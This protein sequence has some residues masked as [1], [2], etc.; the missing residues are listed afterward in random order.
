M[1]IITLS[2]DRLRF[3]DTYLHICQCP[4]NLSSYW[5]QGY[6]NPGIRETGWIYVGMLTINLLVCQV[7]KNK[8]NEN[9][10]LKQNKISKMLK[11]TS[12]YSMIENLCTW[13]MIFLR[14][15]LMKPLFVVKM[16]RKHLTMT[17]TQKIYF[18]FSVLI[19]VTIHW[20][21]QCMIW[22]KKYRYYSWCIL[23]F[24]R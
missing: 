8:D 1:I 7:V 9:K 23:M 13:L 6:K 18:T 3:Y 14:C 10:W 22:T 11:I 5:T 19:Q 16:S 17:M 12:K 4:H 24:Q 21:H 15:L 20:P 2:L